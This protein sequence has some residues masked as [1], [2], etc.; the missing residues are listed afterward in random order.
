MGMYGVVLD[1]GHI[2]QINQLHVGR[3][4][5]PVGRNRDR[6]KKIVAI[7][8]SFLDVLHKRELARCRISID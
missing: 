6:N 3:M 1:I 4:N 2:R 5:S 7:Y 8:C